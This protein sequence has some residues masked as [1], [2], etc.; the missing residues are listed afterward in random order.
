MIY[1]FLAGVCLTLSITLYLKDME[2]RYENSR[3]K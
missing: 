1:L 3:K 2:V